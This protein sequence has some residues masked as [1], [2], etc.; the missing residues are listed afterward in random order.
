MPI[1]RGDQS[2][3]FEVARLIGSIWMSDRTNAAT[4]DLG[5]AIGN[6]VHPESERRPP[7][8]HS[9]SLSHVSLSMSAPTPEYTLFSESSAAAEPGRWRFVLRSSDGAER[10]VADDVEPDARGERLELLTVVRGLE[11]LG[12]PSRVTVM[13]PSAYV[14]EGIRYGVLDWR[15]NGWCWESFGQMIP[16][17][18]RD[19]W[20]RVDRTLQ[21]HRVECRHWRLDGPHW[22][23][24][25][26]PQGEPLAGETVGP[27]AAGLEPSRREPCRSGAGR[28]SCKASSGTCSTPDLSPKRRSGRILAVLKSCRRWLAEAFGSA[29]RLGRAYGHP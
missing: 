24:L 4:T 23:G 28:P 16:V 12:Q 29:N 21:F 20:Q 3:R 9:F 11:A 10:V 13:T 17:K 1:I 2:E 22:A 26:P 25:F 18:D 14:R 8:P 7:G 15:N 5:G 19:L 27:P 6:G